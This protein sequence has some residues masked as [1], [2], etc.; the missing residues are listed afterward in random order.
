MSA[1]F[2]AAD[3]AARTQD[4][5]SSAA[6]KGTPA[7]SSEQAISSY[8]QFCYR[9]IGDRLDRGEP[10]EILADRLKQAATAHTEQ[11]AV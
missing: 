11:H 8:R 4:G 10:D 3:A 7:A 9:L 1:T 6:P 5:D 2:P